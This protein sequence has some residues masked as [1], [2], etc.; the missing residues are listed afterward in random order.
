MLE[1]SSQRYLC[2][3]A[4]ASQTALSKIL[5]AQLVTRGKADAVLA[6]GRKPSARKSEKIARELGLPTI[7]IEDGFLR[8]F[9]TGRGFS[10]LSIVLDRQGIY[11]DS[12]GPSDLEEILG[13]ATDL[14]TDSVMVEAAIEMILRNH[15]SKYNHA[16]SSQLIHPPEGLV[17]VIDQ[18]IGDMSVVYG[19]ATQQSFDLMLQAAIDE[20]PGCQIWVKTH[21]EV[22]EGR[23]KGYLS[24][25]QSTSLP[26]GGRLKVLHGLVSPIGLLKQVSKAYV[27]TSGMGFEALLCGRQVR[28]FGLPWYAG[29]GV[30]QDEQKC[31]RRLRKRSLQE[32]FAAA[33]MKYSRYL[34]S[35]TQQ[36]GNIFD[37]IDTLTYERQIAGLA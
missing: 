17:L 23:K 26:A 8:S 30:T 2:T 18:T 10:A 35:K 13:S 4:I 31:A 6:W 1:V 3:Q 37:V 24:H 33:Y 22:S 16:P 7:W 12:T 11:Y 5:Q 25:I 28:C 21:P 34:N 9:G 15:L 32:M 36:P 19:A 14:L 29:W 27:C 20:N